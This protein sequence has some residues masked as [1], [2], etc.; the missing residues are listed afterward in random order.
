MSL[1]NTGDA[2][3]GVRQK[4]QGPLT[5]VFV[6]GWA[7]DSSVWSPQFEDLA[8]DFSCATVDLRGRG[9]APHALPC[10]IQTAADDVAAVVGSLGLGPVIVVGHDIGGLIALV[11]NQRHPETVLGVVTGDSPIGILPDADE[12]FVALASA[13]RGLGTMA[14]AVALVETVVPPTT[15]PEVAAQ[16][17]ELIMGCPPDIAAGML[18]NRQLDG[19]WDALVKGADQK[20][21]MA[22]WAEHPMGDPTR[23]REM[24]V[25]LR[26]EPIAEAGHFF[27]LERPNI[28]NALLRAFVDDVR[29]DPR[30][31]VAE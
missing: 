27:Q 8:R 3:I 2:Q 26:Q 13:I 15:A 20:P 9:D 6:H 21:F 28:T 23:L 25:F 5:F 24:T 19:H 29:R 30:V 14:D 10:D 4:G 16:V 7:S 18:E 22:L 11:M 31:A 1:I 12:G 17:R